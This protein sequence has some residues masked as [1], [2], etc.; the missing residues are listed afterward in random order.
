[1]L[2][3][4][5]IACLDVKDDQVSQPVQSIEILSERLRIGTHAAQS[6]DNTSA[7]SSTVRVAFS[8]LSGG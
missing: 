1:M 7:C 5:V 2:A 8:C 3:K 4:R 6:A